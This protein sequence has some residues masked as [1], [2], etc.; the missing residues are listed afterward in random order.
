MRAI[1]GDDLRWTWIGSTGLVFFIDHDPDGAS[2]GVPT[3]MVICGDSL[4]DQQHMT[5]PRLR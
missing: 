5:G 3:P 1:H 2:D 4:R